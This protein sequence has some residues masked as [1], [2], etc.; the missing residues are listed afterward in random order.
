MKN[1]TKIFDAHTH[2][3][4]DNGLIHFDIKLDESL[5]KEGKFFSIGLHPWN[6]DGVDPSLVR[7]KLNNYYSDKRV[8][9]LGEC[10]LDRTRNFGE[11]QK[12]IFREHLK[13]AIEKKL[14]VVI[15]CVKAQNEILSIVKKV[16]FKGKLFFHHFN[17]SYIEASHLVSL[18]HFLGVGKNVIKETKLSKYLKD[19]PGSNILVES[20]GEENLLPDII[21]KVCL[22]KDLSREELFKNQIDNL[23][24]AFPLIRF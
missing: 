11:R 23:K 15:H 14:N 20:D 2:H 17:G 7:K 12:D 9:A 18:G 16:N 3:L 24:R 21:D 19:I 6:I 22:L 8:V 4:T 13:F 1:R 10:G 5:P